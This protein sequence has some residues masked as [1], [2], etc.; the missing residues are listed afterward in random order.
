MNFDSGDDATARDGNVAL[1]RTGTGSELARSPMLV[2]SP[3]EDARE[4]M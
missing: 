1:H 2:A 3:Q 4:T